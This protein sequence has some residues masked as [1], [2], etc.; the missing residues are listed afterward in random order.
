MVE[1]AVYVLMTVRDVDLTIHIHAQ[2]KRNV[3]N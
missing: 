1:K 2:H 3:Y